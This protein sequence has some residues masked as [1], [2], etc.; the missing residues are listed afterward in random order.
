MDEQDVVDKQDH[1]DCPNFQGPSFIFYLGNELTQ[2]FLYFNEI[3]MIFFVRSRIIDKAIEL[4]KCL[5][6]SDDKSEV[7]FNIQGAQ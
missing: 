5:A 6:M 4:S 7:I 1:Q 2:N 3:Q